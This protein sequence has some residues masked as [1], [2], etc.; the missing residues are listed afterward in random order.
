MRYQAEP[1]SRLLGHTF[2][3][4]YASFLVFLLFSAFRQGLSH[5][6]SDQAFRS[7]SESEISTS[8]KYQPENPDAHENHGLIKLRDA[9]FPGAA[10]AFEKAT[11]LREGDF[12]LWLRLGYAREGS[13]DLD[14]AAAAYRR[15][16]E[17]APRYS[18]PQYYMGMTLL[19]AG[20]TE[21]GFAYL[22]Q[23]AEFDH[24][25][26]RIVQRLAGR[27]FPGDANA[28]EDAVRPTSGD[29]R[30]SFARYLIKYHYMTDSVRGFLLS[31]E[32]TAAEKNE[33]A[34]YLLHKKNFE[35]ARDVWMSG[36]KNG[37]SNHGDQIYDGGFEAVGQSDTSGLGWQVD[38]KVSATAVVRN[39]ET[40]HSGSSSI[41]I[42]FAGN[43]ELDK[44][45]VSQLAFVKPG[46]RYTLSFF[47]RSVEMISAGLA[48]IA[49]TDGV[50]NE[51]LALSPEI[52][53]TD[54]EWLERKI[55]FA[56]AGS[57]VVLI[58]LRRR[59]CGTSPCPIFGDISLDD[60]HL[61]EQ[62]DVE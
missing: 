33:F 17:R 44:A 9:D 35:L 8:L 2:A 49:V 3:F 4:L 25:I 54:G 6:Y 20:R 43:V 22:G 34:K 5:Y 61:I 26:Y 36:Q 53:K 23:A 57:P 62:A 48:G 45:I 47:V 42:K 11:S 41:T 21:E 1:R 19:N 13:Q 18:R 52:K 40:F 56:S 15:A 24:S 55:T 31:D 60:I 29:S 30:R 12:L 59:A 7:G 46:R 50:T 58:S 37:S 28:I 14:G 10:A 51:L 16:I 39:L 27:T 38:Q 32:L